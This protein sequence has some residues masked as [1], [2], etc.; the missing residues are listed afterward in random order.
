ME[1]LNEFFTQYS[2]IISLNILILI[3]IIVHAKAEGE[4][5]KKFV[6]ILLIGLILFL[7]MK[8]YG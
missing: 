7:I 1:L 5:L 8:L 2:K 6:D 4:N 3:M